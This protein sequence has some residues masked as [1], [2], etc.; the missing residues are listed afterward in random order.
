MTSQR[1]DWRHPLGS[2]EIPR[3]LCRAS[4]IPSEPLLSPWGSGLTTSETEAISP[5]PHTERRH[6]SL[7]FQIFRWA[8]V[9]FCNDQRPSRMC[10]DNTRAQQAVLRVAWTHPEASTGTQAPY[11]LPSLTTD[12]T[13][14]ARDGLTTPANRSSLP[15]PGVGRCYHSTSQD[16]RK[17]PARSVWRLATPT[18][19]HSGW[20]LQR[21][22][23]TA[24]N[25]HR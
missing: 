2:P 21:T 11:A 6:R 22:T 25:S 19:D 10:L 16:P 7:T 1:R 13:S 12:D 24:L 3:E 20:C 17:S 5:Q 23:A 9:D 4:R 15:T 14:A 8:T 18:N